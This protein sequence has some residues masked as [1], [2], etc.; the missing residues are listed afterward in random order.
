MKEHR[1]LFFTD[2]RFTY[3]L[4]LLA[5]LLLSSYFHNKFWWGPDDGFF[6]YISQRILAGD[7]LYTDIQVLHPGPIYYVN[8]LSLKISNGDLVGLRYP[9]V[10]IT[11]LQVAL[12]YKIAMDKGV[13]IC[14]ASASL[15]TAFSFL[16]FVN[17]TPH[18]YTL[19]FAIIITYILVKGDTNLP[20]TIL[21]IGFFV[22]LAFLFRQL[23]G[24]FL[25]IGVTAVLLA[26]HSGTRNTNDTIGTKFVLMSL[27]VFVFLYILKA[28]NLAGFILLGIFPPLILIAVAQRCS[29]SLSQSLRT[30][31][32]L[33]CGAALAALP[34]GLYHLINGTMGPWLHGIFITP[35]TLVASPFFK[36]V[37][38]FD[39]ILINIQQLLAGNIFAMGGLIYWMSLLLAPIGLGILVL[40][41]LMKKDGAF[42]VIGVMALIYS[43]VSIHYEIPIYLN[44][45]IGFVLLGILLTIENARSRKLFAIAS[46]ILSANAILFH[47]AQPLQRGYNGTAMNQRV[48]FE[49][50]KVPNTS[51]LV[52]TSESEKY[53]AVINL[54]EACSSASDTIYT[55]P[56]NPEL[57]FLSGRKS[58]FDFIMSNLGLQ[59][60]DDVEASLKILTG[61]NPPALIIQSE[62]DKYNTALAS[63]LLNSAMPFYVKIDQIDE[64]TIYQH[65]M[66]VQRPACGA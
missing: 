23:T 39:L 22:G 42:P 13:L 63:A 55:F 15:M 36:S 53:T 57:Y 41:K 44:Y 46:I 32:Y 14:V 49:H 10:A 37:S 3:F 7:N 27:A 2:G 4:C 21:L 59:T 9:L 40:R 43:L 66:H 30:I 62:N 8:A 33:S 12:A 6:G 50:R 26:Q 5:A 18:W 61:A 38:Y 52:P 19:C 51:I 58:A 47:A 16:Q 11:V 24:V 48:H 64:W 1:S 65:K 35:F 56:M 25:A 31:I 34:L 60:M 29:I 45:S 28:S 20:R 54:I 17:P